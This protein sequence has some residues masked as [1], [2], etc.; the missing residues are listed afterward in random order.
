MKT[1]DFEKYIK[2]KLSD[3]KFKNGFDKEYEKLKNKLQKSKLK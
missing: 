1:I 2:D 3:P